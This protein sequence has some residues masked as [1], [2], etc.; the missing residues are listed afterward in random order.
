MDAVAGN[1][2]SVVM[3]RPLSDAESYSSFVEQSA[4]GKT[5]RIELPLVNSHVSLR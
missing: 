3:G 4:I 2:G 5:W 1:A